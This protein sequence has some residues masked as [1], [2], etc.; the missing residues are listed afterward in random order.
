MT[1]RAGALIHWAHLAFAPI[2]AVELG[3][4]GLARGLA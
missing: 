2:A 1:L 3:S 4:L